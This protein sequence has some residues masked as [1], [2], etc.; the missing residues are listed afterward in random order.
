[1]SK[2]CP[3][4]TI[5]VTITNEDGKEVVLCL[6]KEDVQHSRKLKDLLE[7]VFQSPAESLFSH[8]ESGVSAGSDKGNRQGALALRL[9]AHRAAPDGKP[10]EK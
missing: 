7:H 4:G 10:A 3:S 1:M 9:T 6:S 8:G 2:G 5:A